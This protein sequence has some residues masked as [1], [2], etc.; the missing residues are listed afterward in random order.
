[1]RY[2]ATVQ[3][4]VW[5]GEIAIPWQALIQPTKTD[6]FSAQGKPNLPTLIKF[7]FIQHKRDT[8]ES[9]SWAGPID[10]GRDDPFTGVV[11]LKEPE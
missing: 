2:A 10:G 1:V 4:S 8:G 5:R 3:Q 11:V 9:A 7:N 6:L